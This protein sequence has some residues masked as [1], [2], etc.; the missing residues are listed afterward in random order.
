MKDSPD[1]HYQVF[2]IHANVPEKA[3]A[4]R[5]MLVA[6]GWR[7]KFLCYLW[8]GDWDALR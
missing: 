1:G 6:E 4:L 8:R 3:E 5:Q 2:I 7:E